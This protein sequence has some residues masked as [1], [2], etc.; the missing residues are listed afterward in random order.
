MFE[1]FKI[2]LALLL[3]WPRGYILIYLIDRS[4]NFSFG[5]KFF[6]G[7]LLG[8]SGFTMDL[9]AANV[10][11]GQ[12]FG[13]LVYALSSVSQIFGFGFLIFI[14]EHKLPYPHFKNLKPLVKKQWQTFQK[15][16]PA[17]ILA[18]GLL[19]ISIFA[20]LVFGF[21]SINDKS[22][23]QFD[24][25][26]GGNLDAREIY[27][28]HVIP[29]DSSQPYYLGGPDSQPL[30]DTMVKVWLS[31]AAGS[32]DYKYVNL[33]G[34]FYYLVLMT[35][36]YFSLPVQVNRLI[37]LMA[38]YLLSSLPLLSLFGNFA[39]PDIFFSIFLYLTIACLF[40]YLAG[41][42]LSFY[43]LSGITLAFSIWTKNEGLSIIFPFILSLTVVL[44]LI[45]KVKFKDFM[46]SWFFAFLTALPW[47]AFLFINHINVIS[48]DFNAINFVVNYQPWSEM[49]ASGFWLNHFNI[50]WF[51]ALAFLVFRG[52][53][54][55]R[56]WPLWF[57]TFTLIFLFSV[58]LGIILFTNKYNDLSIQTRI[59]SQLAPVAVLFLTFCFHNFFAKIKPYARKKAKA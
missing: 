6:A 24:P 44:L 17:E 16:K 45:K 7:W 30:N 46:L 41:A 54:L 22:T 19:L 49:L 21:T 39:Q 15:F 25:I 26:S 12:S 53:Q 33:A 48:S 51:L 3:I 27:N 57:L 38:T 20:R 59:N 23:Y 5:F 37:K 50:L 47:L 13:P 32:F 29:T 52:R 11:G 1:Y 42:G 18:F 40:Y 28:L 34:L 56:D 36:F 31:V 4:K 9:F 55:W 14:A 2:I 35:V 58:Y 43:Y 8:L 10:F